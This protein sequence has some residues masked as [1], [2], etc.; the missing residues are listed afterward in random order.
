MLFCFLITCFTFDILSLFHFRNTDRNRILVVVAVMDGHH[1][2]DD[3]TAALHDVNAGNDVGHWHG[4]T[5]HD[6]DG[7]EEN[8]KAEPTN[9][10]KQHDHGSQKVYALSLIHI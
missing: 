3:L 9:N 1:E 6:H 8:H 2:D 5:Y 4:S 10:Q 7:N